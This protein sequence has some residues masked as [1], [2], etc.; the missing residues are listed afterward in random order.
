MKNPLTS[1]ILEEADN[2]M[3]FVHLMMGKTGKGE[4]FYAYI[5][6][7]PSRYEEFSLISRAK[8]QMNLH[9][10]GDILESG[11]GHEPPPSIRHRMENSHNIDYTFM[12]K[13]KKV[14]EQ[15]SSES[16]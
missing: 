1:E 4:D 10:F 9:E 3:G 2:S 13:V 12:D 15:A 6:V 8:E 14:I 16:R 11:F 7:L 5:S